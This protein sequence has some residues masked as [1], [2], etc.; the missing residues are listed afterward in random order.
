MGPRAAL[1]LA[2][3]VNVPESEGIRLVDIP[4]SASQA[5]VNGFQL[6][7]VERTVGKIAQF[8]SD[9]K[10]D[11]TGQFWQKNE[12]PSFMPLAE[13]KKILVDFFQAGHVEL[14]LYYAGHGTRKGNWCFN[15]DGPEYLSF[16]DIAMLFHTHAPAHREGCKLTIVSDCCHAGAW[17]QA[18]FDFEKANP[19]FNGT[20]KFIEL[21]CATTPDSYTWVDR[22]HG[23]AFTH[24]FVAAYGKATDT[25]VPLLHPEDA[26][27]KTTWCKPT[28]THGNQ[29]WR[30]TTTVQPWELAP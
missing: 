20:G 7:A 24:W 12:R 28:D 2:S 13:L 5:E 8:F 23:F 25:P 17:V 6:A 29:P 26:D 21:H 19:N 18:L 16:Q 22:V 27:D 14:W 4:T 9:R 3:A 15:G 1:I 11:I 10:I 30:K